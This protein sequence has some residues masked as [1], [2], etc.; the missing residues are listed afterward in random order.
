MIP[1]LWHTSSV[2]AF[3][4]AKRA[5]PAYS[6]R[7]TDKGR[8]G[9]EFAQMFRYTVDQLLGGGWIPNQDRAMYVQFKGGWVTFKKWVES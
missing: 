7:L 3:H 1:G 6:K 2:T 4:E 5:L 8:N 9:E